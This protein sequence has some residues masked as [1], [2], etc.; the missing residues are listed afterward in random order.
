MVASKAAHTAAGYLD[1]QFTKTA[2]A[3]VAFRTSKNLPQQEQ[4]ASAATQTA[5]I[6]AVN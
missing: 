6:A 1:A 4:P 2:K 5:S 3:T